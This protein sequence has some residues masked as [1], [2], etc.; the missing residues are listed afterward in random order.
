MKQCAKVQSIPSTVITLHNREIFDSNVIIQQSLQS[1]RY[2]NNRGGKI[3]I[4]KH[5]KKGR[6]FFAE[7]SKMVCTQ[8]SCITKKQ[9]YINIHIN[10]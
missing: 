1:M 7:R 3:F 9:D 8:I 6:C 2:S 10:I 4:A 5:E